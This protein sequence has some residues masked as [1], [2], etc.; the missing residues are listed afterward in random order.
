MII[1]TSS[2]ALEPGADLWILPRI[3]QSK[4]VGQIDWYLNFQISRWQDR[5]PPPL[6]QKLLF[7]LTAT[8]L[9]S[10]IEG[11][12]INQLMVPSSSL[13]PNRWVV[14]LGSFSGPSSWC[15]QVVGTWKQ[16]QK[17]TLRVFLPSRITTKEFQYRWRK[18]EAFDD[19]AVVVD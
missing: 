8:G 1:L 16:L 9:E 12:K 7:L 19:F 4:I 13:L 6:D 18:L 5:T 10:A 11:K 2:N 17:P 3:E 14:Q 15:S